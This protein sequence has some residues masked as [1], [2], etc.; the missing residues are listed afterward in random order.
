MKRAEARRRVERGEKK[1]QVNPDGLFDGRQMA[2]LKQLSRADK[3]LI[4]QLQQKLEEQKR[5]LSARALTVLDIQKNVD[6][7][8]GLLRER[9]DEIERLRQTTASLT[10][11][12]QAAKAESLHKDSA[13][14]TLQSMCDDLQ[15]Q[16]NTQKKQLIAA[17]EEREAEARNVQ[18]T[19]RKLSTYAAVT[20]RFPSPCCFDRRCGGVWCVVCSDFEHEKE[21]LLKRLR[22]ATHENEQLNRDR[23]TYHTQSPLSAMSSPASCAGACCLMQRAGEGSAATRQ[24]I[25]G[26]RCSHPIHATAAQVSGRAVGDGERVQSAALN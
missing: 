22:I 13:N 23:A 16:V 4:S 14:Q 7:F 5:E 9:L 19:A 3:D 15:Y 11:Q 26:K 21:E 20:L 8:A 2:K 18:L 10:A 6:R 24:T 17:K 12:V 1:V 25:A